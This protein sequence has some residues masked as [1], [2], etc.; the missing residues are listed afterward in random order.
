MGNIFKTSELKLNFKK[1]F[2]NKK[3]PILTLDEKWLNLFPDNKMPEHIKELRN[4]VNE[5]LKK[6]GKAVDEIKNLKRLKTQ[7]MQEIVK[8]MEVDDSFL[9][10]L[11][12]K[13]LEKNQKLILEINDQLKDRE[14]ELADIPY[15]IKNANE[16]LISESTIHCYKRME[17][18]TEEIKSLEEDIARMRI[19]LK[20][21]V[22]RKQDLEEE[23]TQMYGYMHDVLGPEVM[24]SLDE[25][26]ML[27]K[28]ME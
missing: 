24:E 21:M 22:I 6:Q 2:H 18:N 15:K 27:R 7:L 14:D 19:R 10:K 12:G 17:T 26:V 20:E 16:K 1:I 4:E 3:F 28:G 8:N 25:G 5:L 13:K 9:G 11:K 23:N